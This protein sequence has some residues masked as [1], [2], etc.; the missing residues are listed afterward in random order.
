MVSSVTGKPVAA[1]LRRGRI[2][3]LAGGAAVA[4]T[5]LTTVSAAASPEV[6][7]TVPVGAAPLGVAVNPST[8]A[9]YVANAV[10][11]TVSVINGRTNTVS[12]TIT[13]GTNPVG[14]AVD[15]LTD[16]VYV[17][18]FAGNVYV[19]DS[20]GSTVQVIRGF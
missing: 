2:A 14:V 4:L 1:G 6:I 16:T 3:L 5:I 15:W 13:V 8:D 9:T 18:N 12:A 19:S 11:N 7:S 17:A 10:D 20:G